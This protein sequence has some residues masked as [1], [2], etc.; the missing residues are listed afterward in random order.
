MRFFYFVFAMCIFCTATAAQGKKDGASQPAP[1]V[2]VNGQLI[3]GKVL[4]IDG[5]HFVAV[6]DLA[7]SLHGTIA[8]GDGQIL[9]T[10]SKLQEPAAQLAASAQ[11]PAP[12]SQ[13]P[14][15]PAPTVTARPL[16][17]GSV[18]I[19]VS[20]YLFHELPPKIRVAAAR[21][22]ARVI[23]PGGMFVLA[24]TIQ[25]GD[26][27]DCDGLIETFPDLLHEPYYDSFARTDLRV[28]FRDAGLKLV[29][30]DIAY[31]TKISVFEKLSSGKRR[32][33][34]QTA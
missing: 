19:A 2:L 28:L 20:I 22:I 1:S 17:T 27:P 7:Q 23:K 31:L 4:E 32:S 14:P 3:K 24:E 13:T 33:R 25:Y 12:I 6:E 21:E 29:E 8:Y 10:I 16:E 18:D 11:A 26:L 30:T 9:L 5:K 15:A 34:K